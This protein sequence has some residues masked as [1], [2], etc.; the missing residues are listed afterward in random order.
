VVR[1]DELA[2]AS[3][4]NALWLTA[5]ALLFWQQFQAARRNGALMNIGE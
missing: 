1:W 3:G 2:W 4:L 5:A